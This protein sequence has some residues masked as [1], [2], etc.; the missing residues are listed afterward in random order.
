MVTAPC[1]AGI[2]EIEKV[3]YSRNSGLAA[4]SRY[5]NHRI[6][7]FDQRLRP[8]PGWGVAGGADDI[9]V[10]AL[11][12]DE[13]DRLYAPDVTRGTV[14]VFS[15]AG[16]LIR[17]I[18]GYL[19]FPGALSVDSTG[20]V[21]V[22]DFHKQL[23]PASDEGPYSL[24]RYDSRGVEVDPWPWNDWRFP[25][26][27]GGFPFAPLDAE[28]NWTRVVSMPDIAVTR[29]G[30]V[31]VVWDRGPAEILRIEAYDLGEEDI[32]DEEI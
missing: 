20:T 13:R 26:H 16:D 11:A 27:S 10:W 3:C 23:E 2:T 5:F 18:G 30:T 29:D 24:C 28:G 32:E 14:R 12:V 19:T 8:F 1:F 17:S 4:R 21:Y 7:K 22:V 9:S 6:Q 15:P 31:H 25:D